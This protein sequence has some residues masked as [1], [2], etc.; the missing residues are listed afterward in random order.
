MLFLSPEEGTP[1]RA[2]GVMVTDKE[3]E[4]LITFWQQNWLEDEPESPWDEMMA[5]EAV[6]ANKDGLVE[7]AIEIIRGTGKASTSM[8]QRRLKVGYPRA[9]RLMDEL[10]DMGVV[11]P[12]RG[13]GRERDVLIDKD[14]EAETYIDEE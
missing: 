10:E 7:Q 3:I 1:T 6:L 2:Q 12:S 13:G 11:G 14:D 9:A 5:S 4:R 8:L